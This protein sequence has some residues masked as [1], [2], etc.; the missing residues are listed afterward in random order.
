MKVSFD[1]VAGAMGKPPEVDINLV[2]LQFGV[3]LSFGFHR[4]KK[5]WL[6]PFACSAA[7]V[8]KDG[9]EFWQVEFNNCDG[10]DFTITIH[11]ETAEEKY[12]FSWCYQCHRMVDSDNCT[13]YVLF[14]PHHSINKGK[15]SSTFSNWSEK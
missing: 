1:T 6:S 15:P 10:S 8:E 9:V 14:I 5:P 12:L 4:P 11:P 3:L 2:D 7:A 13:E